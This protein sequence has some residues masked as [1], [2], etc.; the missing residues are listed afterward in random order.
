MK[1]QKR[2]EGILELPNGKFH[3]TVWTVEDGRRVK[4]EKTVS[5]KSLAKQWRNGLKT[6]VLRGDAS[7][8][9]PR[10]TLK[11]LTSKWLEKRDRHLW[12]KYPQDGLSMHQ[13]RLSIYNH[14]INL[15]LSVIDPQKRVAKLTAEDLDNVIRFAQGKETKN[16]TLN[17]YIR[18]YRQCLKEG[19]ALFPQE[20][21]RWV[22]P[23]IKF[24]PESRR[25]RRRTLTYD[26]EGKVHAALSLISP[27][28]ADYF[29]IAIDTAM[30][31]REN[32]NLR[33]GNVFLS[34]EKFPQNGA[35]EVVA[36]KTDS[37]KTIPLTSRVKEI[38]TRRMNQEMIFPHNATD[39]T[40]LRII[41][42]AIKKASKKAGIPYGRSVAN[43]WTI[44]DLRRTAINRMLIRC[45]FDYDSVCQIS[46]VSIEV[47]LASYSSA[48]SERLLLAIPEPL[49]KPLSSQVGTVDVV[50]ELQNTAQLHLFE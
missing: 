44:H 39:Y 27:D 35:I 36:T 22:P 25:G 32:L 38:L 49:K 23:A 14:S 2:K 17:N 29:I 40:A 5:T 1:K 9:Q 3:V 50:G 7:L 8:T 30:R 24:L 11:E 19:A 13:R 31:A 37:V 21:K 46:G 43:G 48:D 26:E 34:H 45:N 20:L 28:A 33:R 6:D 18:V 15:L 12:N 47:L 42:N 41:E 4:K 10:V 16:R